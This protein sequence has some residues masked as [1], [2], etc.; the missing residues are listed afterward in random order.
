MRH[1]VKKNVGGCLRPMPCAEDEQGVTLS[2]S[3][4]LPA[5]CQ[6]LIAHAADDVKVKVLL[7]LLLDSTTNSCCYGNHSASRVTRLQAT[8]RLRTYL[9]SHTAAS[10]RSNQVCI[11]TLTCCSGAFSNSLANCLPPNR[12]PPSSPSVLPLHPFPY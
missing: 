4:R 11:N 8:Y 2:S 9:L 12:Y 1:A 7:R 3:A 6:L 10:N 5:T